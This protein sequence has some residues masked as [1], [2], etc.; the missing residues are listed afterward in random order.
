MTNDFPVA[1]VRRLR[2]IDGSVDRRRRTMFRQRLRAS[3]AHIGEALREPEA[4]AARWDREGRP[5]AAWVFVAL[6]LTAIVGT[7]AYGMT[8]GVLVGPERMLR[9]GIAFTLAAG[10]AWSLP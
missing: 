9:Q 6:A 2:S 7:T 3:F 1:R 4:F 10:I 5:Y 8:M